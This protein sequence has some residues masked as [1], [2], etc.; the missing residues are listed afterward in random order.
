MA[1]KEV[2]TSLVHAALIQE[3]VDQGATKL[4]LVLPRE[5]RSQSGSLTAAIAKNKQPTPARGEPVGSRLGYWGHGRDKS[6]GDHW[7]REAVSEANWG[8]CVRVGATI[9]AFVD[10]FEKYV[11]RGVFTEARCEIEWFPF[12]NGHS[13]VPVVISTGFS[14]PP[15]GTYIKSIGIGILG[16]RQHDFAASSASAKR[17]SCASTIRASVDCFCDDASSARQTILRSRALRI[18]TYGDGGRSA[19]H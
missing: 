19:C 3:A 13:C 15:S 17:E 8:K 4:D 7:K 1:L 6:L 10:G 11:F 18:H 5:H 9:G 12:F 14:I 16:T 2:D